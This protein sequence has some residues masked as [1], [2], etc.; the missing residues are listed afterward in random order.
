MKEKSCSSTYCF[1]L[2]VLRH[3]HDDLEPMLQVPDLNDVLH[4]VLD[5][6]LGQVIRLGPHHVLLAAVLAKKSWAVLEWLDAPLGPT[7]HKI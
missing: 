6:V 5:G 3:R 1:D 4:P 2:A 7:Q